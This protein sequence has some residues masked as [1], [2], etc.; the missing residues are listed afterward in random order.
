[1]RI[2]DSDV[3]VELYRGAGQVPP[4]QG[5]LKRVGDRA[6]ALLLILPDGTKSPDFHRIG[7]QAVPFATDAL[8][9]MRYQRVYAAEELAGPRS[10]GFARILRVRV[11]GGGDAWLIV[12]RDGAELSAAF[13]L[14]L[15]GL[16]PHL[17]V[18]VA[19]YLALAE[20]RVQAAFADRVA[21]KFQTGVLRLN[22]AGI[23][24]TASPFALDAL[25]NT[26]TVF[27][28]I[29]GKLGLPMPAAK[30]LADTLQDYE[31]GTVRD[32]VAVQID[33]LQM[34]IQPDQMGQ[35]PTALVHL[36]AMMPPIAAAA[37]TLAQLAQISLS[38]A[39][40]ALK[41]ADGL[42]IAEAGAALGL[43]LETARNYSKQIYSK[44]DLRGQSDLI[45][46]V[47]NS[48]IPLI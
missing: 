16:G 2:E 6:T 38:E 15:S 43:T 46:Y 13:T 31:T 44:M 42:T 9:R 3:L 34:L 32:A 29:G 20:M 30:T 45:R 8:L 28:Q 17:A 41:L 12:G 35:N 19:S 36:R 10:F 1:M 26:E 11:E 4:W 47:K 5:F 21:Q 33:N 7:G 23:I 37:P 39:R 27:G 40:F 18:A 14:M 24:L 48:V 25:A 22:L